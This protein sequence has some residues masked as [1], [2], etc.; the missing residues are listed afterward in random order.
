MGH[1]GL[2]AGSRA[3]VFAFCQGCRLPSLPHAEQCHLLGVTLHVVGRSPPE[4][5][6]PPC[7]RTSPPRHRSLL[8]ATHPVM[9]SRWLFLGGR[10]TSEN[11]PLRTAGPPSAASELPGT[12]GLLLPGRWAQCP[13]GSALSRPGAAP[14]FRRA[15]LSGGW[16]RRRGTGPD[17]ATGPTA[18]APPPAAGRASCST[19]IDAPSA[20]SSL[21][22]GSSAGADREGG[23]SQAGQRRPGV[24]RSWSL[25]GPRW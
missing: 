15:L 11:R 7:S 10:V 21:C 9:P 17:P 23:G 12:L 6:W 18:G 5:V 13:G 19:C 16:P 14:E 24:G 3:H 4:S 2:Q 22:R 25:L 20:L 1:P 8:P